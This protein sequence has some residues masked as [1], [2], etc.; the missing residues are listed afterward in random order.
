MAYCTL[1]DIKKSIPEETLVQLTDD[2]NAG[3]VNQARID[4]AVEGADG[5]IDSYLSAQ[6]SVPVEPVPRVVNK[7]SVDIAVYNLYGRRVEKIPE[8]RETRYRNA[9]RLLEKIAEGKVN[10]GEAAEPEETANAD[11]AQVSGGKR[12]F[13]RRKLRGF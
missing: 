4:E 7:L 3:V 8:V 13:T 2:E 9:V 1:T 6:Y 12:I 5:E 11:R 10:I